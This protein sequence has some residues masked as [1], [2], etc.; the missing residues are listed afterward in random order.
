MVYL[1]ALLCGVPILHSRGTGIDGF[2][3][4]IPSRA[5][6]DPHSITEIRDGLLHLLENEGALKAW[7][8]QHHEDIKE[9]F[10]K[11]HYLAEYSLT[12]HR[13]CLKENDQLDQGAP[14][15]SQ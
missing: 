11:E 4:G 13:L 7:L 9:S 8:Y 10:S 5:A 3:D 15:S 14:I 6:V 1:E 2:I 12:I